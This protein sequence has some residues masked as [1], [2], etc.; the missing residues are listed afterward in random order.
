VFGLFAAFLAA[1]AL[2]IAGPWLGFLRV[3]FVICGV[4]MTAGAVLVGLGAVLITRGGRRPEYWTTDFFDE[5][6]A[7][8]LGG[9]GEG[10]TL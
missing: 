7:D 3:L 4:V 2:S 8:D 6:R 10:S 5:R 1:S 9:A